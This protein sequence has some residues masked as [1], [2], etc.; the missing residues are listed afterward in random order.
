LT[1]GFVPY[2]PTRS[3]ARRSADAAERV[4]MWRAEP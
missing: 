3:T 2:H 4:G 1:C